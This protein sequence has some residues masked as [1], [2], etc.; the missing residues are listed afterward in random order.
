M[1]V[2]A[3]VGVSRNTLRHDDTHTHT[4]THSDL[5][6]IMLPVN[7]VRAG[8]YYD[9]WK[10]TQRGRKKWLKKKPQSEQRGENSTHLSS[11]G[12]REPKEATEQH[13]IQHL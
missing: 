3:T 10:L 1:D 12:R 4:H 11:E 7:T 5:K 8:R 6:V 2:P 9:F 13:Y